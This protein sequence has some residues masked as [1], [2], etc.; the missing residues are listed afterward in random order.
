MRTLL[1]AINPIISLVF[2]AFLIS[3]AS[4]SHAQNYTF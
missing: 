2:I 1:R 3:S 4:C